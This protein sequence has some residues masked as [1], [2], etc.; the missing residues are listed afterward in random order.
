MKHERESQGTLRPECSMQV[1]NG[2]LI[3][4]ELTECE[5]GV[6]EEVDKSELIAD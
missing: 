5:I 6:D 4:A 3:N 2:L 1:N